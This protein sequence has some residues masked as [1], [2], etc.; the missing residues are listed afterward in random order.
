MEVGEDG[1]GASGVLG[2]NG[3]SALGIDLSL[4]HHVVEK[5]VFGL[6]RESTIPNV[7]KSR[8]ALLPMSSISTSE[9]YQ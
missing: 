6:R 8:S 5:D 2:S 1:S 9:Q 4:P 7:G 3:V